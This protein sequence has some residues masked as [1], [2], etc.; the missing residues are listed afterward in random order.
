MLQEQRVTLEAMPAN[1][2]RVFK[3]LQTFILEVMDKEEE[4]EGEDEG[5]L[6][7]SCYFNGRYIRFVP[8]MW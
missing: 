1:E 3:A 2:S 4:E 7:L 6:T 8:Q 5:T